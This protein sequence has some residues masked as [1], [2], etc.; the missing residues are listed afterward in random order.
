MLAL[1]ESQCDGRRR[2]GKRRGLGGYGG[3][4][5]HVNGLLAL[6]LLV[7]ALGA[8]P[9]MAAA[10]RILALG[11]S[12][13]AGYG[14]P[15][16]ES[17]PTQ[18][19]AKLAADGFPAEVINAG[20]SGDTTAGG[21]ARLHWALGD[22]PQYALVELG[23]NDMLR[24]LDPDEAYA[25]LDKILAQLKGAQVQTLLL[26]MRAAANW[27]PAYQHR[28]DA[29]YPKLAAKWKVPLYPFF[30]AGVALD[31]KLTQADGLHPNAQGVAV[32]VARL[33]P[34]VERLIAPAAARR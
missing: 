15:P 18:L 29:I 28:F 22:K 20:V 26:G 31:P 27:G 13:T 9:A 30:L 17:F 3:F 1:G 8:L 4:T 34:A 33:A 32:I 10:P 21:L 25:N 6:A 16:G 14:L 19:Q 24:G 12:L 11:D 5:A 2:G 23:A 7:L